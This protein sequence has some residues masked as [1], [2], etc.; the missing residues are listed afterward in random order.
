VQEAERAATPAELGAPVTEEFA[1]AVGL[2][3]LRTQKARGPGRP[4]QEP[5]AP[6]PPAQP[7]AP[8]PLPKELLYQSL[9]QA[10]EAVSKYIGV[11]QED[12]QFIA[13][14]T[15]SVHPLA[16]YYMGQ[17][18]PLVALWSVAIIGVVGYIGVKWKKVSEEAARERPAE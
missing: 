11:T 2:G 14:L 17:A 8:P 3:E 5:M 15:E 7:P 12:Q 13:G 9:V 1:D 6:A 18:N 16:S 4:A 10:D